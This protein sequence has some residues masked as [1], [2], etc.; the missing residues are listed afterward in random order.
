MKSYLALTALYDHQEYNLIP[1]D[2][3][4]LCDLLFA[5]GGIFEINEI[6]SALFF[7]IF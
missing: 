1:V 4:V 2:N 5:Q 3:I 7:H 6:H